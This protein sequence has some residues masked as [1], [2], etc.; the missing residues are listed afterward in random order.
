MT[1]KW[2]QAELETS[3]EHTKIRVLADEH[4]KIQKKTFTKWVQSHLRKA[5]GQVPKLDDLYVDLRDGR[6]LLKLLEVISGDNPGKLSKGKMR[7]HHMEN[8]KKVLDFLKYKKVQLE[9]IGNH[10]IVDGNPKIIL[11]LIW[12]IILRFQ[13]QD[14]QV[15]TESKDQRSAKS[16]LLLWCQRNT[17]GYN[18][19]KVVDFSRS[20]RSGL[21]F[22]AIIHKHRPDLIEYDQLLASP[23]NYMGNLNNAFK[24][25]E[26]ELGLPQL[27]DP[28]D[29]DVEVPDDKSIMTYVV[30]YYHY[31]SKMKS[32]GV[33][34]RRIA[35]V[36]AQMR[37]NDKLINEYETLV[38]NLLSWI[39]KMTEDLSDRS[40][41]NTISGVQALVTDFNQFRTVEKPPKFAEKS[42]L[43]AMLFIL[44]T[45]M[46]ANNQRPYVPDEEKT[47][48]HV[49][50]AWEL[51]EHAEHEREIALREEMIRLEKLEQLAARFDR[52]A[53]LRHTWL[54]DNMANVAEDNFGTDVYATEA[55][56]KKH[57]ALETD[58]KEYESRLEAMLKLASELEA[59]NYHDKDQIMERC[60][61]ISNLWKTL[62]KQL[63]ERRKRLEVAAGLFNVFEEM[64][65]ILLGMEEIKVQ[66]QSEE[67]GKHLSEVETL[68]QQ[69]NMLGTSLEAYKQH[70]TQVN[71]Q[72]GLYADKK[73]ANSNEKYFSPDSTVIVTRQT[74]LENAYRETAALSDERKDKLQES[75][76]HH[77]FYVDADEEQ[78]WINEKVQLLAAIDSLPTDLSNAL[79]MSRKLETLVEEVSAHNSQFQ[80]VL[81][82]GGQIDK[83]RVSKLKESWADL[84]S[85]VDE[86]KLFVTAGLELQQFISDCMECDNSLS[87]M[88]QV[89]ASDE[90]GRDEQ[91]TLALLRKLD[92]LDEDLKSH[93][94]D[95]DLL[96]QQKEKITTLGDTSTEDKIFQL[97]QTHCHT[98]DEQLQARRSRLQD[99]LSYHQFCNQANALDLWID[100]EFAVLSS[101][102]I[103]DDLETSKF[104]SQR[105]ANLEQDITAQEKQL[106]AVSTVADNLISANSEH[107][108]SLAECKDA[109]TARW[110]ELAT[111]VSAKKQQLHTAFG[112]QNFSQ[113]IKETMALIAEKAALLNRDDDESD[114]SNV[115]FRQRRL[116]SVEREIVALTDKVNDFESEV[117]VL[118]EQHPEE[119][120]VIAE[121]HQELLSA[122]EDL[123]ENLARVKQ[124]VGQSG[125]LKQL[126]EQLNDFISWL[127]EMLEKASSQDLTEGISE[128]EKAIKEH[129]ELKVEILAQQS[130]YEA[131]KVHGTSLISG[132]SGDPQEEQAKQ[133]LDKLEQDWTAVLDAWQQRMDL[134]EQCK[135]Y[136]GYLQEVK[137][138]DGTMS[139]LSEETAVGE[140]E[141]KDYPIVSKKH[142]TL[143]SSL[144]VLGGKID[145]ITGTAQQL[146]D[147]QHYAATDIQNSVDELKNKYDN[148]QEQLAMLEKQLHELEEYQQYADHT[149]EFTDWMREKIDLEWPEDLDDQQK[150]CAVLQSE[151]AVASDRKD[152]LLKDGENL[153]Q[154][155]PQF[156]D[157]V[158]EHVADI[159]AVWDLLIDKSTELDQEL[160]TGKEDDSFVKG[161]YQVSE[162][163]D[164]IEADL[165][166]EK[167]PTDLD[168]AENFLNEH[169][170][171]MAVLDK[172]T[173]DFEGLPLPSEPIAESYKSHEELQQRLADLKEKANNNLSGLELS[174]KQLLQLKLLEE[175]EKWIREHLELAKS[176]EFPSSLTEASTLIN[177]HKVLDAIVKEHEKIFEAACD[178]ATQ[179][180]SGDNI[181]SGDLLLAKVVELQELWE[182]LKVEVERR[183]N[184]LH[185]AQ[186]AQQFYYD[187]S[188]NEIWLGEQEI[189]L[190]IDDLGKSSSEADTLLVS[191]KEYSETVTNYNSDLQILSNRAD[192]LVSTNERESEKLSDV[193][194]N[195]QST[196][197]NLMETAAKRQAKLEESFELF[198]LLEGVEE[199]KQWVAERQS[200][201]IIDELGDNTEEAMKSLDTFVAG[202]NTTVTQGVQQIDQLSSMG[203]ELLQKWPGC[204]K[205]QV[206][207]ALESV[208]E[209]WEKFNKDLMEFEKDLKLNLKVMQYFLSVKCLS[210]SIQEF[211]QSINKDPGHNCVE[212]KLLLLKHG[213]LCYSTEAFKQ[214]KDHLSTLCHELMKETS[215]EQADTVEMAFLELEASFEKM[216]AL[217]SQNRQMLIDS[218]KLQCF[219]AITNYLSEWYNMMKEEIMNT[220]PSGGSSS[221]E[222]MILDHENRMLLLDSRQ[223]NYEFL[224]NE[225]KQLSEDEHYAIE[226]VN[227]AAANVT[228]LRNFVYKSY[229]D[230]LEELNIYL[231]AVQQYEKMLAIEATLINAEHDVKVEHITGDDLDKVEGLL[232]KLSNLDANFSIVDDT[233]PMLSSVTKYEHVPDS[234]TDDTITAVSATEA[235]IST[236]ES[237]QVPIINLEITTTEDTIPQDIAVTPDEDEEADKLAEPVVLPNGKPL[238]GILKHRRHS[239][240]EGY[241][242]GG[243]DQERPAAVRKLSCDNI[244]EGGTELSDVDESQSP[245]QSNA[246]V[247]VVDGIE[248]DNVANSTREETT[249][250]TYHKKSVD[251][252]ADTLMFGEQAN[253]MSPKKLVHFAEQP[254]IVVGTGAGPSD[255]EDSD[256]YYERMESPP[257]PTLSPQA[258]TAL[259]GYKQRMMGSEVPIDVVEPVTDI[260][261]STSTATDDLIISEKLTESK[262]ISETV[263]KPPSPPNTVSTDADGDTKVSS[264]DTTEPSPTSPDVFPTDGSSDVPVAAK[265]QAKENQPPPAVKRYNSFSTAMSGQ[266]RYSMS[267][268]VTGKGDVQIPDRYE[269][270]LHRKHE[271]E[272]ATK[273]A[274]NRSWHLYHTVVYQA[275]LSFYKDHKHALMGK[276]A[277]NILYLK[278]ATC[279]KQKIIRRRNMCS[280]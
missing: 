188:E 168:Q 165:V 112:I 113:E 275:Q 87:L 253:E 246:G 21:A 230:K 36:L 67:L 272:S 136:L 182:E 22:N 24:V 76:R 32:E 15:D 251:E 80:R 49:N 8:V 156:A 108:T 193:M 262:D 25:A 4:E 70:I 122:W 114:L 234:P 225:Q 131:L 256:D 5:T 43:E 119:A 57:E 258:N 50:K 245:K 194:A 28:E 69:H 278:M 133:L 77:Q 89:L 153:K 12:T 180:A 38:T 123:K 75:L 73:Y 252:L 35:K 81:A 200:V 60:D 267:E 229:D 134:L 177:Q 266:N 257:P 231:E 233:V 218:H 55:A 163:I 279:E 172:L 189:F 116:M 214:Q 16:A 27:L 223:K 183:D 170:K 157:E 254:A 104:L 10:D 18:N 23:S 29:I 216:Q 101:M 26:Q 47:V 139:N 169:K 90:I 211:S 192:E 248:A 19:V 121:K 129:N 215:E 46:R 224:L 115:L 238:K 79:L 217:L 154:Q 276:P 37:D 3:F 30:S 244:I 41:P 164:N 111:L 150:H 13:I 48:A 137:V 239:D 198:V 268:S 52:K 44:H 98:V 42:N 2:Q 85:Q 187:V 148:L 210:D 261:T 271:M 184:I 173:K 128:A 206:T 54:S 221:V 51:M 159:A 220:Y 65:T 205:A 72:A 249:V 64:K 269:G 110:D 204:D 45:Q 277:T 227:Q 222:G 109:I 93:K 264:K 31:F 117:K 135:N 124:Q 138:L 259:L 58:V 68:L 186:L 95:I 219:L 106:I 158:D 102:E 149:K 120:T 273:K 263:Q 155:Y 191:H 9:N 78:S 242:S 197:D 62:V 265:P 171:L 107:S 59:A 167:V 11:G 179:L 280:E 127:D 53:I 166:E 39:Q 160:A 97:L 237:Q 84:E 91:S 7:I 66:L 145:G 199:F 181:R 99:T 71:Q 270:Q 130:S 208:G 118:T 232:L 243:D 141:L 201:L 212:V 228:A 132:S 61:D 6:V 14:I 241:L 56:I 247:D 236:T 1:S 203:K 185:Q 86:K 174:K 103:P 209:L 105:L 176:E 144:A 125:N 17:A 196:Y 255:S 162:H 74:E 202:K 20:W 226:E 250:V 40:F 94:R 152:E 190:T 240:T 146:I 82:D 34:S 100:D 207:E 143:Q 142:Q 140:A 83:D 235:E 88:E 151:I 63:E 175:E 195:L 147:D 213:E 161:T 260:P 92:V 274:S 96:E 33:R 178:Y 126:L